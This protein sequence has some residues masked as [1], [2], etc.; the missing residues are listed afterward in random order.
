M[1]TLSPLFMG[2]KTAVTNSLY[3]QETMTLSV[4]LLSGQTR[5]RPWPTWDTDNDLEL[6]V[7]GQA[8]IYSDRIQLYDKGTDDDNNVVYKPV[9]EDSNPF[10]WLQ[11]R[12]TKAWLSDADGDGDTDFLLGTT[13]GTIVFGLNINGEW[14]FFK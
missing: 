12:N 1:V 3:K 11:A 4:A 14:L 5:P 2:K 10:R 8:P 6:L 7:S 9:A 13:D